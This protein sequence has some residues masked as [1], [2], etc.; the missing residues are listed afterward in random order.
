MPETKDIH[1]ALGSPEIE[2]CCQPARWI[3]AVEPLRNESPWKCTGNYDF[4]PKGQK[5]E[6]KP[7]WV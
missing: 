3:L 6:F 4:L 1:P 2:T 7:E 5:W